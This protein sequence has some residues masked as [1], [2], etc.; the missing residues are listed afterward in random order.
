MTIEISYD[1]GIPHTIADKLSRQGIIKDGNADKQ[2]QSK[3]HHGHQTESF[4]RVG[5]NTKNQYPARVA[6]RK[7]PID[8]IGTATQQ[9]R[10]SRPSVCRRKE[11]VDTCNHPGKS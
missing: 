1:F 2:Q 10:N 3:S 6:G 4:G 11:I 9:R 5:P 7:R 8:K